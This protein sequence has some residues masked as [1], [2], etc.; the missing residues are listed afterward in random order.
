MPKK[1]CVL[2]KTA[3]EISL[4]SN[5][6]RRFFTKKLS[7]SIKFALK[8]NKMEFKAIAKGGGRLY[9]F[10]SSPKK[11]QSTLS[12][13]PGIHSIA[14]ARH[15]K[16]ADYNQLKDSVL[17][18]AK[19]FLKKG[20]S[21]ALDVNASQNKSFSSHG[22]EHRLGA[23]VQ[24]EIPG[25]RVQLKGPEKEI[26]IEIRKK[27]FFIYSSEEK[28]LGGL[29]LGV[30][31]SIAFFFK[32]QKDE[33]LAALLLMKRG[34]N[35]FPVVKK[36]SKDMERHLEKLVP[37]NAFREF[38]LTEE[39]GLSDLVKERNLKALATSDSK[40]DGRSLASYKA[41]D[42]KHGLVVLRPLLLFPEENK[43]RLER[44]FH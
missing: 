14:L 31:G 26:F 16:P 17:K 8:K 15:F 35:L 23:E 5:F 9:L 44:L 28:G 34:C 6:V 24:K 11:A 19:A 33:L 32:G 3:S 1:E 25:L 21:F 27:D 38:A 40:T 42:S 18:H 10:C 12:K 29:P 39:K 7:E 43:K 22:L 30:E 36:K 13:L 20:D 2:V 37:F 4:K 41:F